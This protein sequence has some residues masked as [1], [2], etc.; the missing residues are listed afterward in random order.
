VVDVESPFGGRERQLGRPVKFRDRGNE[1]GPMPEKP[2]RRPPRLG[3]HDK[4]ILTELGYPAERVASLR[5]KGV[6]RGNTE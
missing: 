3:E 1:D 6:I 5:R 4:E 2:P